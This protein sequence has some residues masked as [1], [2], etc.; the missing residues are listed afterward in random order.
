MV[1]MFINDAAAG[2]GPENQPELVGRSY[3][4]GFQTG[5]FRTFFL[6]GEVRV[7]SRTLS[8]LLLVGACV[9]PRKRKRRTNR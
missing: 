9:R 5:W 2:V 1:I 4:G 3:A 6:S 8:G 7:V